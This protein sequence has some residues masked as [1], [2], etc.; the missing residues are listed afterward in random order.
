MDD[1]KK[2]GFAVHANLNRCTAFSAVVLSNTH[3]NLFQMDC[4]N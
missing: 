2:R 3:K 1:L 4:H